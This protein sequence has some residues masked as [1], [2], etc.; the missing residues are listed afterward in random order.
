MPKSLGGTLRVELGPSTATAVVLATVHAGA[1][2]GAL[3]LPLYPWSALVTA[4]ALLASAWR[5]LT[6]HA[7]RRGTGAVVGLAHLD[8]GRWQ[9]TTARGERIDPC[10]LSSAFVHSRLLILSFSSSRGRI[11]VLVPEG[12]TDPN[13]SRR[14]RI[15]LRRLSAASAAPRDGGARRRAWLSLRQGVRRFGSAFRVRLG[16]RASMRDAG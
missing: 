11:D 9:I 4:V 3:A 12:A 15:A 14:L 13:G 16:K 1:A 6:L 5:S 2:L 10:M 7:F 8:S